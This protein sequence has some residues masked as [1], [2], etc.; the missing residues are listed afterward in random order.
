MNDN[1]RVSNTVSRDFPEYST[2]WTQ[3]G[4]FSAITYGAEKSIILFLSSTTYV[5]LDQIPIATHHDTYLSGR[6][7]GGQNLNV[8]L[9]RIQKVGFSLRQ[10]DGA[11]NWAVRQ[12][13]ISKQ[14]TSNQR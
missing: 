7:I 11:I 5:I 6:I 10:I 4:Y 3:G 8:G 9:K 12:K 2:R 14:R 1:L 13:T